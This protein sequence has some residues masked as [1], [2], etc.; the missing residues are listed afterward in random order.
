[1]DFYTAVL[2]QSDGYWVSLCLENGV[3]GQGT[4][5]EQAIA[6]LKDAISSLQ[7]VY[8]SEPDVYRHTPIPVE[9]L[10]EFLQIESP[11]PTTETYELRAIPA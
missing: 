1:M 8:D 10:H 5:Q 9:E 3:V 11:T 7:E 6:N 2:R 4:T